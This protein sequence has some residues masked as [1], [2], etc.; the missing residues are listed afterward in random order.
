MKPVILDIGSYALKVGFGGEYAPRLD[1]PL[2]FGKIK[3]MDYLLKKRIFKMLNINDLK[4]EYFFGNDCLY[5]QN[6]VDMEWIYD[7]RKIGDVFFFDKIFEYALDGLKVSS[8]NQ[9]FLITQPFFS[10]ALS[11]FGAKLFS[12]YNAYVIIPAFQPL[13]NL[14]A[15]GFKTGLVIDIGHSLTQ[16]TPVINGVL[17]VDGVRVIDLGGKDITELLMKLLLERRAFDGLKDSVVVSK[18]SIAENLKHLFCYVSRNPADELEGPKRSQLGVKFP[19]LSN[20]TIEIG[21]ERIL[22]PEVLF[23]P[24]DKNVEPLDLLLYE[25]IAGFEPAIQQALLGNI[26][27]T[28]GTS[29]LP[30]LAERL[31]EEL[32]RRFIDYDYKIN[33]IPFAKYGNPRYSTFFGA[34]KL[35]MEID[36]ALKVS[37]VDYEYAG[38]FN[39]PVAFMEEFDRIFEKA[40]SVELKPN[41]ISVKNFYNSRL[42][43]QIYNALNSQRV[44]SLFEL[45]NQLQRC[46]SELYQIIETLLTNEIIEGEFQEASFINLQFQEEQEE[47]PVQRESIP[48]EPA[49]EPIYDEEESYIPTFQRLDTERPTVETSKAIEEGLVEEEPQYEFTFQKIDA[50]KKEDW[51]KDPTILSGKAKTGPKTEV[52]SDAGFTFERIDREKS[53]EYAK[54]PTI[55]PETQY[56]APRKATEEP[57]GFTFE[58]IDKEKAAEWAQDETIITEAKKRPSRDLLVPID[59]GPSFAKADKEM[60][61]E[62]EKTGLISIPKKATPKGFFEQPA[63]TKG[64]LLAEG[65]TFLQIREQQIPKPRKVM[66]EDLLKPKAIDQGTNIPVASELPTFLHL[67]GQVSEEQLKAIKEIEEEERKR[68]EKEEKLL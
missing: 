54:D 14:I 1:I 11:E 39:V 15:A 40:T 23:V 10:D 49:P 8:M 13:L 64:D 35:A 18:E 29:L 25:V 19:L 61:H 45:G 41:L 2:V 26:F 17:V 42:Y 63:Q 68:K 51:A 5:L 20:E 27:L 55:L 7:G 16:I 66:I 46:P 50:E 59:E 36:D 43:Q 32:V 58:K 3:E 4:Q 37:K 6:Y 9:T 57:E 56:V 62:W 47:V 67:R 24:Q 53:E 34:A 28:G 38:K 52:V 12:N 21:V 33:I 44:T 60:E 48:S 22:A 31:Y 30:G 65:P